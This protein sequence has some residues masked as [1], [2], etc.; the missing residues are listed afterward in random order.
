MLLNQLAKE[1]YNVYIDS[2]KNLEVYILSEIQNCCH[3][4]STSVVFMTRSFVN[5]GCCISFSHMA[6]QTV[7]I[8]SQKVPTAASRLPEIRI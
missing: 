1:L 6:E 7:L 3:R 2:G 5:D 4:K 8:H